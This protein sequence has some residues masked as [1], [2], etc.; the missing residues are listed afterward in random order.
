LT[1]QKIKDI[2][3]PSLDDQQIIEKVEH[4][5]AKVMRFLNQ[6]TFKFP[7]QLD[8]K[9]FTIKEFFVI[10]ETV[11]DRIGNE[12]L[13]ESQKY[14]DT[15]ALQQKRARSPKGRPRSPRRRKGAKKS[16]GLQ[17]S[18]L[19]IHRSYPTI[20]HVYLQQILDQKESA[21]VKQ[22]SKDVTFRRLAS[23][24]YRY[25]YSSNSFD[26]TYVSDVL[27]IEQAVPGV[28]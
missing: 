12:L 25:C 20:E 2:V 11:M 21:I 8:I 1:S 28:K 3:L 9:P 18:F 7:R 13:D 4:P 5:F 10:S 14:A 27:Q 26:K 6:E 19:R 24:I 15:L 22:R 16:E 23:E 17:P